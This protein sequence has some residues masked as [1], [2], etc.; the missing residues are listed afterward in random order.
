MNL[1]LP[2]ENKELFAQAR[3]RLPVGGT[4]W[5]ATGGYIG[6]QLSIRFERSDF[7]C[8]ARESVFFPNKPT[9]L[10]I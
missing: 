5:R 2:Q 10:V 6:D 4:D 9:C 8:D 7:F 3:E 1:R